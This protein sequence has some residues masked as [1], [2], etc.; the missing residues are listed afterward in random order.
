ML[1]WKSSF[2]EHNWADSKGTPDS[3]PRDGGGSTLCFSGK[4]ETHCQLYLPREHQGTGRQGVSEVGASTVH[5]D[6]KYRNRNLTIETKKHTQ[7]FNNYL[8]WTNW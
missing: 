2:T 5:S 6:N 4:T 7:L 3:S 1:L 8:V